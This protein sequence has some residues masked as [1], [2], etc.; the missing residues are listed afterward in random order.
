MGH[1]VAELEQ[2]GEAR[3]DVAHRLDELFSWNWTAQADKI[4]A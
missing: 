3:S 1:H 2:L 4:A